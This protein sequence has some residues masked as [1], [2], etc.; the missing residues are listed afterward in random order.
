MFKHLSFSLLTAPSVKPK[1]LLMDPFFK[2]ACCPLYLTFFL[3]IYSQQD[4]AV[5]T[6]TIHYTLL[7]QG[8][9]CKGQLLTEE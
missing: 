6:G 7:G 1:R 8:V 3:L 5:Q 2:L 9:K 4:D